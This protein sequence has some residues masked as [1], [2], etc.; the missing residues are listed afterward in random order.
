MFTVSQTWKATYPQ[1]LAGV[2]AMRNVANPE[3]HPAL[4]ALKGELEE[5]LRARFVD[6][7]ELRAFEPLPT[8]K[9][10]YKRFRKTYHVQMQLESVALKCRPIPRVAA[11]VEA[12]F[13]AELKNLLLTAGHDREI[14]QPPIRLDVATGVERYIRING[15]QQVLKAGDMYIADA[16]GIMSSVIY[17][18]DKR[19]QIRADTRKVLFTVYAPPGVEEL[20]VYWHLEDIE[21]N[22][23]LVAPEAE[24]ELLKVYDAS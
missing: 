22:V 19:T 20:A 21:A 13:I 2:L 14:V 11:L 23:K 12:M 16:E 17:G 1:A 9:A 6:R 7:E 10:Y 8:Y 18:P 3:R 4:D 24:T 15:Q 5:Q